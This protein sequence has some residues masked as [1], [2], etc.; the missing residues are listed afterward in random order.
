MHSLKSRL[1]GHITDILNYQRDEIPNETI[2]LIASVILG[3]DNELVQEFA[4]YE[5]IPT[6]EILYTN[7]EYVV[8]KFLIPNVA[9]GISFPSNYSISANAN[10]LNVNDGRDVIFSGTYTTLDNLTLATAI[11]GTR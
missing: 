1:I 6:I 8:Q 3:A 5:G 7:K 10:Q 2:L 11:F 4:D 9:V